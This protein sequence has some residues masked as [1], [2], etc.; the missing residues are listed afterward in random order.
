LRRNPYIVITTDYLNANPIAIELGIGT[1][2]HLGR[3]VVA[4]SI[5]DLLGSGADPL[6]V[7]LAVTLPRDSS[8]TEFKRIVQGALFEAKRAGSHII[9]GDSKLGRSRALLAVG[10]G[11]ARNRHALFLKN[12]AQPGHIIWVSGPLGGVAAAVW[13]Y[14]RPELGRTWKRWAKST[15]LIPQLPLAKSRRLAKLPFPKAGTDISDG[16][17]ADLMSVCAASGVGA[18]LISPTIPICSQ[19][20]EAAKVAG[21]PAWKFAFASGGDFQFLATAPPEASQ[22][23]RTSGFVEIGQIVKRPGITILNDSGR[24]VTASISGH[25]DHRGKTFSEEVDALIRD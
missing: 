2:F 6:A 24:R 25:L 8:P 9:G 23:L 11:S 18:R 14:M 12:S 22:Q 16:L 19:V 3:L 10:I 20:R 1:P 13:G 4:A 17:G 21:V 5:S 7:L 15:L